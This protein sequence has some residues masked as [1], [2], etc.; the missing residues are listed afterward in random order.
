MSCAS[1]KVSVMS[2]V[3]WQSRF[4]GMLEQLSHEE[5]KV[6]HQDDANEEKMVEA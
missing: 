5:E 2:G 1:G 6:S 3:I 4:D